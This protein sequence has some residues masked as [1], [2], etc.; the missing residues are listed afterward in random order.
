MPNMVKDKVAVVTGSSKGIGRAEAMA[1]AEQG[2]KLVIN[3]RTK[4]PVDEVVAAIEKS[5]GVAIANYDS[6]S[7]AEGAKKIIG[8]A[9]DTFGRIDILVNNAGGVNDLAMVYDRRPKDWD[10][11]IQVNLSG[12]FYCIHFAATQM[13]RQAYGRIINTASHASLGSAGSCDYSAAKEGVVGLTR[14]VARDLSEYGVTC[15]AIRPVA[16]TDQTLGTFAEDMVK[17]ALGETQ[18]EEYMRLLREI[19]TPEAVTP[20]VV[21]LASEQA[22]NV[23]NCVFEVYGG[24]IGIYPEPETVDQVINNDKG[25]SAE[26]LV[27]LLP[28]TLT[29]GR[30][31]NLP[32]IMLGPIADFI[33][34]N[35]SS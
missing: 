5:G 29:K 34:A 28:K 27:Q 4:G 26:D 17:R 35:T 7:T 18:G 25:W 31:R 15:N 24:H 33:N 3:G 23:N 20:L 6:V 10:E 8:T 32:P 22:D 1:L 14:A 9:I 21:Y 30:V 19:Y 12:A 16:S 11:L 13:K 2:A